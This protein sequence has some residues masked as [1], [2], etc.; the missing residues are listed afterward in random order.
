MNKL[1]YLIND[2]DKQIKDIK[3]L[4]YKK[5]AAIKEIERLNKIIER[6]NNE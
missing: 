4:K 2:L 3:E 6:L 5:E 1:D